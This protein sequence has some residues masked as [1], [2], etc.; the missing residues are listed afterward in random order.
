MSDNQVAEAR[1]KLEVDVVQDF[2]PAQFLGKMSDFYHGAFFYIRS[3]VI[4][5]FERI[6][7][8]LLFTTAL[9]LAL[10]TSKAPPF[11]V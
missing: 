5:K 2:A 4:T 10:P 11:T 8:M 1:F 7:A 3:C 6:M 9:V